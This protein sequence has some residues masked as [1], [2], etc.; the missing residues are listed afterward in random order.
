MFGFAER[1]AASLARGG[2]KVVRL[3]GH[4]TK[5]LTERGHAVS[6]SLGREMLDLYA[7]LNRQQQTGFFLGLLDEFSPHP[8]AVLAAAKRYA[9]EPSAERLV[10]L[11]TLAEP[12]R[13][14][15]LR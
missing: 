10:E 12:P 1:R 11:H 2:V 4:C 6:L 15:L 5:L 9:E 3:L 13:Q 14:E 7:E 8:D